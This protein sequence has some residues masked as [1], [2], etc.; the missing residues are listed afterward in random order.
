[1]LHRRLMSMLLPVFE[2]DITLL[3]MLFMIPWFIRLCIQRPLP[4]YLSLC[5]DAFSISTDR[6]LCALSV[7]L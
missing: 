5:A 3:A 7:S 6:R 2:D 1:M 4:K